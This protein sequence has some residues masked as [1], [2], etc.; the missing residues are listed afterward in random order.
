MKKFIVV[1]L[2]CSSTTPA[3]ATEAKLENIRVDTSVT[4]VE[5]GADTLM[6]PAI[7]AIA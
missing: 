4:A 1:L 3:G 2:L 5:R 7:A 6:I